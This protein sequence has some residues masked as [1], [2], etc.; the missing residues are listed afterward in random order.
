[1]RFKHGIHTI[2]LFIDALAPMSE[3]TSELLKLLRERYPDGLTASIDPPKTTVIS[4]GADLAYGLLNVH[5]DPTKGWKR[6]KIGERSEFTPTK[7]GLK[8][9]SIVAIAF[10]DAAKEGEEE[11]VF[12]VEWPREDE[13]MY[14][15]A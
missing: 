8:D 15:Q 4:A 2:Y 12:E 5:N 1:M 9:N 7:A 13:E 14:D 11:V 6:I 3:T 10:L